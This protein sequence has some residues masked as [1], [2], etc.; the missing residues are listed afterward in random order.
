M[1]FRGLRAAETEGF[2]LYAHLPGFQEFQGFILI[3]PANWITYDLNGSNWI[4][5]KCGQNVGTDQR[6]LSLCN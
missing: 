6:R 2:E 3:R 4:S 1:G 5:F